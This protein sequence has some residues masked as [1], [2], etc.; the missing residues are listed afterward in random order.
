M[1]LQRAQK[2]YIVA[3]SV[4]IQKCKLMEK[5]TGITLHKASPCGKTFFFVL[6]TFV[7]FH[8]NNGHS[9]PPSAFKISKI[10]ILEYKF[11]S[12][13]PKH[14][15]F[16]RLQIALTT[17]I[18][19]FGCPDISKSSLI[20][21]TNVLVQIV[22]NPVQRDILTIQSPSITNMCYYHNSLFVLLI[23]R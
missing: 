22:S 8:R 20:Q 5:G 23:C 4:G 19:F 17:L 1:T 3:L 10:E 13:H 14:D 12:T 9:W 21:F 11:S 15:Y 6:H 2:S 16:G 18:Y 7:C